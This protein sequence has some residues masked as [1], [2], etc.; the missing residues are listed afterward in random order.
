MDPHRSSSSDFAA[1]FAVLI[2]GLEL[3]AIKS[4]EFNTQPYEF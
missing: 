1:A 4:D 2:F 3:V